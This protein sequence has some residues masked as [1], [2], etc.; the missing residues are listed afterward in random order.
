M[1]KNISFLMNLILAGFFLAVIGQQSSNAQIVNEVARKRISIGVGMFQDF[2]INIPD[3]MSNRN[4]NQGFQTFAAY[5]VPFGKSN[6]ALSVGLGFRAENLYVKNGYFVSTEDS[7]YLADPPDTISVKRSKLALPYIELPIEFYVKTKIKLSV[8]LGFKIAYMFPAHS[9]YVGENYDTGM[10]Q[11]LRV[12]YREIKN[13]EQFSYG[14]T[15]RVGYRWFNVTC[16][17]SI[18]KLFQQGRGPRGADIYPISLGFVLM[19]F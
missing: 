17:Y 11:E 4:M 5:N 18:S 3:G 15:L 16:Y 13:L 14:P 2:W 12:K 6:F 1:K 10:G 9:K 19:P 7:T 8:G